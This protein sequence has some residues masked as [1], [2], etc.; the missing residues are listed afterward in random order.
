M[1][2]Y[3]GWEPAMEYS[4]KILTPPI[5]CAWQVLWKDL[6]HLLHDN[7]QRNIS[8]IYLKVM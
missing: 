2:R 1:W 4:E 7:I 6:A 5:V 8:V 3:V